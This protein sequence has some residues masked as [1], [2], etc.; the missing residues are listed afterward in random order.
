[1]GMFKQQKL[2][3]KLQPHGVSSWIVIYTCLII[4]AISGMSSIYMYIHIYIYIYIHI[5]CRPERFWWNCL[6]TCC[7]PPPV[8]SSKSFCHHLCIS[9]WRSRP[10]LTAF[11]YIN[12]KPWHSNSADYMRVGYIF[13]VSR[14]SRLRGYST[15]VSQL[16]TETSP[17]KRLRIQFYPVPGNKIWF[18]EITFGTNPTKILFQRWSRYGANNS[19]P[20]MQLGS[21]Y[22]MII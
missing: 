12:L 21:L 10:P 16:G 4:D 7:P 13:S 5:H 19:S 11:N 3:P 1:M 2:T 17:G 18:T 20:C 15:A 8:D 14:S 9:V 22:D 6:C